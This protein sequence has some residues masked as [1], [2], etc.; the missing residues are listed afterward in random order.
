LDPEA[1]KALV[2]G[3]ADRKNGTGKQTYFIHVH[4]SVIIIIIIMVLAYQRA[5]ADFRNV[6]PERSS[7]LWPVPRTSAKNLYRQG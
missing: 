1:S 5:I 6:Q 3:L 7:H 4:A 2:L